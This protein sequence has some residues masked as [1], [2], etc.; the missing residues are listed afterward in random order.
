VAHDIRMLKHKKIWLGAVFCL[1]YNM[2]TKRML[3]L[4]YHKMHFTVLDIFFV[5]RL[6]T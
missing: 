1:H 4:K 6:D 3:I 5:A 2:K